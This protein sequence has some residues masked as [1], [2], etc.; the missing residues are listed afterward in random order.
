RT[1]SVTPSLPQHG[2]SG[3]IPCPLQEST[4]IAHLINKQSTKKQ[5]HTEIFFLS[6]LLFVFSQFTVTFVCKNP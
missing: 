5:P 2:G 1:S 6:G 4:L 3:R